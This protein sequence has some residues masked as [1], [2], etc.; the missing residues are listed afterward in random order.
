MK[1]S[2]L[3]SIGIQEL[4]KNELKNVTGGGVGTK[5]T[6]TDTSVCGVPPANTI[7][8]CIS[9]RCKLELID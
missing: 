8:R 9:G 7:Y 5:C 3:K 1:K 2:N 6:G 4:S